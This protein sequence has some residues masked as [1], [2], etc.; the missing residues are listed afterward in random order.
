MT[1]S[2]FKKV[3]A[4]AIAMLVL[5][6]SGIQISAKTEDT[7]YTVSFD[8]N[9]GT[10]TA[11]AVETASADNNETIVLPSYTGTKSGYTFAGWAVTND[12]VSTTYYSVYA[13]GTTL[14]VSKDTKLYAV[15]TTSTTATFFIRLDGTTPYEPSQYSGSSYTAGITIANVVK[16][17]IWVCDTTGAKVLAGLNAVPTDAQIK[18]VF[19][20]YDPTSQYV[21]WYVIKYA[22]SWHVDGVIQKKAEITLTYDGN[23]DGDVSNVPL[24]SQYYVGSSVTVGTTGGNSGAVTVPTRTGYTFAGWNTAADGSGT[25]YASGA[26]FT[27]NQAT[28]LYAQWIPNTGTSYAVQSIDA[29]DG[30]V[31][32]TV[33]RYGASGNAINVYGSD[34]TLA[35][36]IYEGDTYPGTVLNGT[37]AGD[38]SSVLKIYFVKAP[39][40]VTYINDDNTVLQTSTEYIGSRIDS[41]TGAVPEKTI[42]ATYTY[43]FSGWKLTSG[44]EGSNSTVGT[45]NLVYT[46][47]YESTYIDYTVTYDLNGGTEP[48]GTQLIYTNQHQGDATPVIA[49]PVKEADETYKYVFAGWSPKVTDT[50]T[51]SVTYV[52]QWTPLKIMTVSADS[53]SGVYQGTA[54]TL[55]A[56]TADVEDAV[57]EYS[58]DNG[59]TWSTEL[60]S[61]T[62]AGTTNVL[63]R[64][65]KDGYAEAVTSASITVFRRTVV[66]TSGSDSKTYDGTALTNSTVK[67]TGEG[68]VEGQGAVYTF[69]GTQTDVG[70][71][72]NVFAYVLAEGTSGDNY[73]IV[74]DTGTLTVNAV[75]YPTPVT[76]DTD[77]SSSTTSADDTAAETVTTASNTRSMTPNTGDQTNLPLAAAGILFGT[78]AA[79]F[80]VVY[81][82][83]YSK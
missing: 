29:G 14:T 7:I 80:A 44:T 9:G 2:I 24:G 28:V 62:D 71:S 36:Y 4:A 18:A 55:S 45:T 66:M 30:T 68:F 72:A 59:V 5:F 13:P 32:K 76:N 65:Q 43:T 79:I 60:P 15:W 34:K 46:A 42:D 64:A 61:R 56:A 52:A 53:I 47:V 50:V 17:D 48:E 67:E 77:T 63:I 31:I 11:P 22:G 16:A 40:S 41:Y 3:V 39:L 73:S 6:H 37:I 57:I 23:G 21:T 78:F 19:P 74:T 54:Y 1:R 20:S 49:D 27:I 38:G 81:R 8:T 83:K 82:K 70:A 25:S 58:T 12:L 75:R 33:V 26:S 10:G 51:G 69:T 35:G